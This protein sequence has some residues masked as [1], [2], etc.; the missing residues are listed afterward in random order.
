MS[1]RGRQ[2]QR[3]EALLVAMLCRGEEGR[4]SVGLGRRG[5]VKR[6][7][8]WPSGER[9]Q[10]NEGQGWVVVAIRERMWPTAVRRGF[11]RTRVRDGSAWL[12]AREC[13]LAVKRGFMSKMR[14][15]RGLGWVVMTTREMKPLAKI[16]EDTE[17]GPKRDDTPRAGVDITLQCGFS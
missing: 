6:E 9:L 16:S 5:V 8:M 7:R 4:R 14:Q 11:R 17:R 15:R 10:K 1:G 3:R 12:S 2:D 13:G